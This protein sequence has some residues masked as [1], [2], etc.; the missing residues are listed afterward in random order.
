MEHAQLIDDLESAIKLWKS[1]QKSRD[2]SP[3]SRAS[4]EAHR[5]KLLTATR[6]LATALEGPR[7]AALEISKSPAGHAALRTALMLH[8]FDNWASDEIKTAHDLAKQTGAEELL[9]GTPS[10]I[11][12]VKNKTSMSSFFTIEGV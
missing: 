9:I 11:S 7:N 10:K 6:G 12:F 8:V 2:A 5:K 4:Q 1:E 3:S